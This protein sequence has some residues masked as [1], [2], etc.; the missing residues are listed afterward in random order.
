MSGKNRKQVVVLQIREGRI[1][2]LPVGFYLAY[3]NDV[4]IKEGSIV[5]TG[6][7]TDSAIAEEEVKKDGESE[8]R[9]ESV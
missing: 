7:I 8:S 9:T 6:K 5:F 4:K 1:P 3:I 2:F